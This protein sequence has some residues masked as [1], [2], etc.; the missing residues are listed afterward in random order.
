[1]IFS[2]ILASLLDVQQLLK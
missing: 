1:L 2:G